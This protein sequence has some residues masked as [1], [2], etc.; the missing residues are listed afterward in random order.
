MKQ[1]DKKVSS[2]DPQNGGHFSC[3]KP[4]PHLRTSTVVE[5]Q[6]T[7][8]LTYVLVRR[9][10]LRLL[11]LDCRYPRDLLQPAREKKN[12]CYFCERMNGLGHSRLWSD[13]ELHCAGLEW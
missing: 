1:S 8:A 4:V 2:K 13:V 11:N 7:Y 9:V 10:S 5:G 6:R 3:R 12:F